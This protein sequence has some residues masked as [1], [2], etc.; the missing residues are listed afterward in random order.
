MSW[1][2]ETYRAGDLCRIVT[3]PFSSNVDDA[4]VQGEL[5]SQGRSP[6]EIYA[7]VFKGRA[8]VSPIRYDAG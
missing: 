3:M 2:A 1:D 7:S 5:Q 8:H 4:E 6:C